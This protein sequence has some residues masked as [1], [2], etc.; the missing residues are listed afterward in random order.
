MP[1][2]RSESAQDVQKKWVERIARAKEV[3]KNWKDLFRV[4]LGLAYLDGRQN[5]GYPQNEWITINKVYSH[6]K[7]TLPTL[8]KADPYF[9]VKLKRSFN[10]TPE[11]YAVYE[12]KAKVRQAMLNYL[13]TELGLKKKTRLS[14]QDAQFSY[15]IAKTHYKADVEK[16]PD[17]GK[18]MLGENEEPLIDDD[19]GE[20]L[21]EPDEVPINERYCI[22]RVHPDDFLWDEDAGPLDDTWSW[23]AQGVTTT[24]EEAKKDRRFNKSALREIERKGIT[25]D[26]EDKERDKRKKGDMN[27]KAGANFQDNWHQKDEEDTF[28]YWEIY[29]L[30]HNEWLIVAEEG[31]RPLMNPDAIPEGIEKHPFSILR[32]TLRDNSPYPIPP[33]SQGIDPQKEYNLA[34]SRLLTHRKRFNRKYIV[35]P[36][37]EEEELSKLASGDDGTFIKAVDS[38]AVTPIRDAPMDQQGYIEIGYLNQDMIELFG[39]ST[40]EARGIAGADSATQAGILDKRLEVKEGDAMSEVIDFVLDIAQKLDMQVKA[41]I[42]RDEAVRVVGPEG[43]IWQLVRESDYEDIAGEFGYDVNVGSTIPQLPQMERT[44]WMAF[45]SL[46]SN[47]PH[48]ALSKTLLKEMAELHHLENEQLIEELHGIVQQMMGGQ[49]P[50]PGGAGSQPGVGEDRPV[51]SIGGQLAGMLPGMGGQ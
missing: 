41:H 17:G 39:G 10:P 5:P 11:A 4:D 23:V 1:R 29:D 27:P 36:S 40:D 16:N 24:R 34:R 7:A 43:E 22:E 47:F 19:T 3:R 33:I 14:I 6:L 51:S 37:V 13:K 38:D 44:S 2:R 49:L 9:Y 31:L 35:N 42:S 18:P 48:L 26:D 50:M 20:P 28:R 21:T 30:T 12:A 32:F 46:L 8:Y 45:L 15:G 25:K